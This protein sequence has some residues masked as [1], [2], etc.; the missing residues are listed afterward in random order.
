MND[1]VANACQPSTG[2]SGRGSSTMK[3]T[4]EAISSVTMFNAFIPMTSP[5][6]RTATPDCPI[7]P[8][9][10]CEGKIPG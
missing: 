7:T 2:A 4:R 6:M 5:K 9:A 1:Y 10:G 3:P 8:A